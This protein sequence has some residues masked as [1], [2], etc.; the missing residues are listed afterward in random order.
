MDA[1]TAFSMPSALAPGHRWEISLAV[2]G[3]RLDETM[4][5]RADGFEP[6]SGTRSE[7]FSSAADALRRLGERGSELLAAAARRSEAPT[8]ADAAEDGARLTGMLG[9]GVVPGLEAWSAVWQAQARAVS[10]WWDPS[11]WKAGADAMAALAPG[12]AA[13]VLSRLSPVR[14]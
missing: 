11:A 1:T 4:T 2:S 7:R 9:G 5:Y 3:D 13:S 12:S 14:R 8:P 10:A 6:V